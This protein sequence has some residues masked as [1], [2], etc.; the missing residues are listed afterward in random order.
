[1]FRT[2]RLGVIEDPG[3][4]RT[5]RARAALMGLA[6]AYMNAVAR[7]DDRARHLLRLFQTKYNEY[8]PL[9]SAAS[10]I[11]YP[12]SISIDGLYG[13]QT[14]QAFLYTLFPAPAI[15]GGLTSA[16]VSALPSTQAELGAWFQRVLFARASS[17]VSPVV[18]E[19]DRLARTTPSADVFAVVG[20]WV[21]GFVEDMLTDTFGQEPPVLADT[22]PIPVQEPISIPASQPSGSMAVTAPRYE[23]TITT[24]YRSLA[25]TL[26]TAPRYTSWLQQN[27]PFVA[28]I[29][30]V[31]AVTSLLGF[32]SY[33]Q[34]KKRRRR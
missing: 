10:T 26:V 7:S 33:K 19:V 13:T 9:L 20:A 22:P 32:H 15:V 24:S 23:Q 3:S 14:R 27:W 29:T 4:T 17:V 1:M 25:P 12:T 6:W 2:R 31:V 18:L 34:G 21:F 16:E 28:A 11:P 30:G 8:R 5:T